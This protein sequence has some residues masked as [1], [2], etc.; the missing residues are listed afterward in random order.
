MFERAKK[1]AEELSDAAKQMGFTFQSAF[2]DAILEGK[3][4]SDVF[5]S[6]L[7]DIARMALRS[8]ITAPLGNFFGGLFGGFRAGGGP[9]S[10]GR[11]YMVG[12]D[13]PEL[14]TPGGNGFITPNA[15]MSAAAGSSI[16]YNIDARGVDEQR[17]MQRM[18]PLLEQ[19]VETTRSLVKR[20][21]LEGS[22]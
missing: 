20:D 10:S 2:E 13:G 18:I 5:K 4:L 11:S 6:L 17:I 16:S 19:T 8:A 14:F 12:E 15:A 7:K 1:G 3:K 22:L 9:V 21:K